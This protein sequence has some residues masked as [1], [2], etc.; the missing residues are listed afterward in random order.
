M[1]ED[2]LNFTPQLFYLPD[3]PNNENGIP[4]Q[5]ASCVLFKTDNEYFLITAKH[6]FNNI[7]ISD[8]I[9]F[10]NDGISER[11]Y[12]DV[13]FF[14]KTRGYD[15]IDIA[16]IKL[17]TKLTEKVKQRYTFLNYKNID[18]MHNFDEADTY[19]L[20][21]FINN[22]TQ[23]KRN[24]FLSTP[25]SI[26]TQIKRLS[27]INDLGLNDIEN[28][29]L[30]YNKRKQAFLFEKIKQFGPS[31]LTG[32]SGGGIWHVRQ[33]SIKPNVQYC[34]LVGIMIEQLIGTN[35]G[36]VVGTKIFLALEI[37]ESYFGVVYNKSTGSL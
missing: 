27:K 33:N 11:L 6:V 26:L 16:I 5:V 3:R 14:V 25:F 31:N 22:Q 10:L 18:F 23:L 19:L 21:G 17:D 30:R 12:G 36:I 28:I 32:L 29:T 34:F 37:L 9:I 1:E 35:R 8:I 20:L 4:E 7:R 24:V 2:L 13:G 15:N